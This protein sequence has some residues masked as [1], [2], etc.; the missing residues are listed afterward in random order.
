MKLHKITKFI[1]RGFQ[2][3]TMKGGFHQ[4][5]KDLKKQHYTSTEK[6]DI[7][8]TSIIVM[9]DGKYVHGGLSDRIRG[10]TSIYHYCK[11]H[12]I[13]FYL[14]YTYPFKMEDYLEP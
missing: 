1:Q 7:H 9:V 3:L 2:I 4:I 13:P 5:E 12:Q 10:I 6:K 14:N 8:S 11:D